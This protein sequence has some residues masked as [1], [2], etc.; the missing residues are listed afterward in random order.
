MID[1]S[2]VLT[3]SCV[4]AAM[5]Y[6]YALGRLEDPV[7]QKVVSVFEDSVINRAPLQAIVAENVVTIQYCDS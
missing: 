1:R 2:T 3:V 6:T 7:F 5:S 4:L